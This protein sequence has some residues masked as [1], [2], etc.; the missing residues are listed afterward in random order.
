MPS[1]SQPAHSRPSILVV[2]DDADAR[3]LLLFFLELEGWRVDT[4]ADGQEAIYRLGRSVPD[5]M[6]LDLSMPR[7]D[8]W[9]VLARI[10]VEP[11]WQTMPVVVMSADH[12][13]RTVVSEFGVNEFLA[14]PFTMDRL[15]ST[16]RRI[17]EDPGR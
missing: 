8:G 6:L 16:L 12:R 4:A 7:M 3:S 2:E 15:R 11:A 14:K 13:Q 17:L 9:T 5:V 10:A 1:T